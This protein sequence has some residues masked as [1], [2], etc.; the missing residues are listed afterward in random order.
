MP[1]PFFKNTNIIAVLGLQSAPL[2]LNTEIIETAASIVEDR[3]STRILEML[4]PDAQSAFAR[5]VENDDDDEVM[6]IL[7]KN[8]INITSILSQEIEMMKKEMAN[9]AEEVEGRSSCVVF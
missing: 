2:M 5:A 9:I 3:A 7:K 8:G 1:I 6:A 4:S